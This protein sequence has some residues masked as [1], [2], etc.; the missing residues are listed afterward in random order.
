[1]GSGGAMAAS[2]RR[3]W[4]RIFWAVVTVDATGA[5]TLIFASEGNQDAAGRGV[6][7]GLGIILLIIV[8][9]L[10]GL[11]WLFKTPFVRVPVFVAM[12]LPGLWLA[13]AYLSQ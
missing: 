9:V 3:W 5:L 6:Q 10:A 7:S 12:A 8:A 2:T 13:S 1:M 11:G 4:D